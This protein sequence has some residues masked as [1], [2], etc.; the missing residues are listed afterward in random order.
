MFKN[1][2]RNVMRTRY[3]IGKRPL[4]VYTGTLDAFQRIDLLLRAMRIV[5]ESSHDA[6]LLMIGSVIN[7]SDLAKDKQLADEMGIRD[8]VIF[9]DEHDFEEVPYFL[10]SADVTVVPRPSCPGFPIKLLNYMAAA[11]PIVTFEG[12]AKGLKHM[13]N[14]VVVKDYDWEG[15]G[16]GIVR[17]L[18]DPALAKRLGNN[19]RSTIEGRFDW[20][21]LARQIEGIYRQMVP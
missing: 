14:A 4:V 21:T 1:K 15:F 11:K 12:S 13:V 20:A 7:H 10:A 19:A 2:D 18:E 8:N 9:A 17:L 5:V 6:V 3:N 16:K